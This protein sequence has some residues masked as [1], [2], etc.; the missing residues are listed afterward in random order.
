M[1]LGRI[2]LSLQ[3]QAGGSPATRASS[4]QQVSV[5]ICRY[6][7]R[8]KLVKMLWL[9]FT[10]HNFDIFKTISTKTPILTRIWVTLQL[11]CCPRQKPIDILRSVRRKIKKN[12]GRR[13]EIAS[14][15][16]VWN[17]QCFIFS[18]LILGPG[19]NW[20]LAR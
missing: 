8:S 16:T 19:L 5:E 12:V 18:F 7:L 2:T 13:D 11:M 9:F 1:N 4:E 17:K 14:G 15:F 20:F 10:V 3:W 6:R